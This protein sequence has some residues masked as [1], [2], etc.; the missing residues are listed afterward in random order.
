MRV[1]ILLVTSAMVLMGAVLV[2]GRRRWLRRERA[3]VEVRIAANR[4]VPLFATVDDSL[5]LKTNARRD[6]A[7][8]MRARAAHIES[9]ASASQVLRMVKR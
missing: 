2:I 4:A 8:R 5:R 7:D 6:T 3:A 9:G 1:W